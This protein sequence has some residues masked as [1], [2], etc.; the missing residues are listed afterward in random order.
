[1]RFETDSLNILLK[2]KGK[3]GFPNW[4]MTIKYSAVAKES[5]QR[6]SSN[7]FQMC[8]ID[9]V[10]FRLLRWDWFRY[11]PVPQPCKLTG[12]RNVGGWTALLPVVRSFPGRT[13]RHQSHTNAQTSSHGCAMIATE[14]FSQPLKRLAC[15][16]LGPDLWSVLGRHHGSRCVENSLRLYALTFMCFSSTVP[17]QQTAHSYSQSLIKFLRNIFR[18]HNFSISLPLKMQVTH[19]YYA[20]SQPRNAI[21]L[22]KK[23][24]PSLAYAAITRYMRFNLLAPITLFRAG[25]GLTGPPSGF[26]CAIAK[27]RKIFSS[28]LVTLPNYSLRTSQKEKLPGQARS[29]HQSRFVDPTS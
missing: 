12:A 22:E 25:G 14:T 29:G 18:D 11:L 24:I 15:F 10:A 6:Q 2:K 21:M 4:S 3:F 23:H 7:A 9:K 13:V 26:S 28:Y 27:R 17:G 5:Y 19:L 8:D 16:E 1:M 20:Q